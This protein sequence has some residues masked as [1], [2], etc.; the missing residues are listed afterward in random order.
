[1]WC[2]DEQWCDHL[3]YLSEVRDG[4]H[5]Q[6]LAGINPRDEFHRIA[7]R[8]FSGFFTSA[9]DRAADIIR[10]VSA[11]QLGQDI[12]AL[13]LRRPSAT[14]TYMTSDNPLGNPMDRAARAAGRWMRTRVYRIE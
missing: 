8:Q 13:G 5:L 9:Y 4:I 11:A 7:L 3:A 2:L 6:A 12:T 10:D 1:M 14:W